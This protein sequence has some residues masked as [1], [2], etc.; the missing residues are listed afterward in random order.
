[1]P[2]VEKYGKWNKLHFNEQIPLIETPRCNCTQLFD[3]KTKASHLLGID[4]P[5]TLWMWFKSH[6]NSAVSS[7]NLSFV[8]IRIGQMTKWRQPQ[9]HQQHLPCFNLIDEFRCCSAA[10]GEH[11]CAVAKRVPVES[12]CS[13]V[14]CSVGVSMLYCYTHFLAFLLKGSAPTRFP[15]LTRDDC[16]FAAFKRH[17]H[18]CG[19]MWIVNSPH[20]SQCTHKHIVKVCFIRLMFTVDWWRRPTKLTWRWS[21]TL[22]RT[23]VRI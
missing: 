17:I 10:T 12:R 20:I 7:W 8:S 22:G 11:C 23:A 4:A 14:V 16:I 6:Q 15:V 2:G 9:Q 5:P 21:V 18:K 1:M 3:P 13:V 19:S